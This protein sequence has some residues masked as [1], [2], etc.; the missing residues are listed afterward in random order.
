MRLWTALRIE[1]VKVYRR[2]ST[3]LGFVALTALVVLVVIAAAHR[4]N[5]GEQL[6]RS[7]A[8]DFIIEGKLVAAPFVAYLVLIPSCVLFL[9]VLASI[10]AGD[11]I[12]AERRTGTL[13]TVLTHPV[14]RGVL[15]AAKFLVCTLHTIALTAFLGCL[16]LGLGLAFFGRGDLLAMGEGIRLIPEGEALW[17]LALGYAMGAWCAIAIATIALFFSA[18]LRSGAA[19]AGAAV[20]LL[21]LCSTADQILNLDWLSPYLMRMHI[22]AIMKLFQRTIPVAEV[23]K[24][25]GVMGLYIAVPLV[26]GFWIFRRKDVL[27]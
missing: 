23:L 18:L 6:R 3:Y 26:L 22:T 19:A 27:C 20:A 17:R 14:S 9:P 8:D 12:A 5:P 15:Y 25:V 1:M 16:A 21:L 4:H 10:V 11:Q 24:S 7:L 2:R 13:R